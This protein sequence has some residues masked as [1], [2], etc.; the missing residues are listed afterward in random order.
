[1]KKFHVLAAAV[2]VALAST[3]AVAQTV[4]G[5]GHARPDANGDGVIDRAEAA[6]FPRLAEKFDQLDKN[7]DGKLSADERP[8]HRRG[9][10]G[11]R[12][13][14]ERGAQLKALDT[15][16][17][18]RISRTEAQSA[19]GPMAARFDQMDANH[20]GYLDRS[21][22]QARIT[23][24][25][26][27]FFAGA[28]GNRDGRLTRDEFAVEQGARS[29]ERREKIAERAQAAGKQLPSRPAPTEAEQ[30]ARAGQAFARMDANKDGVVSKTEFDA[31]KP[32]HK[33]RKMQMSRG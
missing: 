12:K 17:D 2:A 27:E 3:L 20:D 16:Q 19:K 8:Q 6:K 9:M 7:K 1:M 18:S 28:D 4:P 24:H 11:G 32:A 5:T 30:V 31:F 29:A 26:A 10:Q 13:G 21:D 15:D 25:R 22:K 33:G 14:G 23:E